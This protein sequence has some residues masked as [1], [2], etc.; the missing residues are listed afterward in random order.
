MGL[1]TDDLFAGLSMLALWLLIAGLVVAFS[2]AR[3][4]KRGST[5]LALDVTRNAAY[6]FIALACA[7]VVM[8]VFSILTSR[9]VS[10]DN[11]TARWV[12]SQDDAVKSPVCGDGELSSRADVVAVCGG[13]VEN[14]P[15]APR[16]VIYLGTV[17][18]ILASAAIAWAIYNAALRA[19]AGKPF[20][21]RVSRGFRV[22]PIVVMASAVLG[23]LLHQIGMALAARSL[24]WDAGMEPPFSLN[25]PL[26]PFAVGV[27]LFALS[28]VFAH[29]E[30]LQKETEGLV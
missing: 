21:P 30:H 24:E 10:L 13:V 26:W 9:Q 11:E 25:V 22:V 3:A 2:I 15:F 17:L 1:S 6:V 4:R 18:S 8:N 12:L 19:G 5:T 28:A 7:G 14:V 23:D 20:H 27:G 29:A 16:L